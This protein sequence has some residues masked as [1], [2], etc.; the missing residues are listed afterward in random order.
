MGMLALWQ[1]LSS[2]W[3][4]CKGMP[5]SGEWSGRAGWCASR[6]RCI[7]ASAFLADL[8]SAPPTAAISSLPVSTRVGIGGRCG[9]HT[10]GSYC[11]LISS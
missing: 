10:R 9:T 8:R 1:S 4:A 11:R 2:K 5:P 7:G 3:S 6:D